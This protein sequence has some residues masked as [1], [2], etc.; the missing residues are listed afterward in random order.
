[1]DNKLCSYSYNSSQTLKSEM[2]TDLNPEHILGGSLKM[3]NIQY[4][5]YI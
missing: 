4:R 2:N 3:F 1:M 5:A